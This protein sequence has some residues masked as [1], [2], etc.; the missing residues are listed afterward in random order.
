MTHLPPPVN[1]PSTPSI[2]A[3]DIN[4]LYNININ[5]LK[6]TG[7]FS[8][9]VTATNRRDNAPRAL[10][11]MERGGLVG[12][13]AAMVLHEK[14]ILR[15]ANH[16]SIIRLHQ[17]IQTP[18]QVF[19]ELDL[20]TTDLFEY[21]MIHKRLNEADTALVM[22]QLLSAVA[23]LHDTDIIH[24]DIKPENILI[25]TPADIKLADFGLA[26]VV[27]AWSVKNT[28]MGTS[29]YIAPEIIRSIEMQSGVPH[30]TTR[31]DVKMV[32]I[33]ACG[34]VIAFMLSGKPPF[35]GQVKTGSERRALLNNINR[36]VMFNNA[37]WEGVSE[38][39]KDLV[40]CLLEQNIEKRIT[41]EKALKH[42]F[43]ENHGAKRFAKLYEHVPLRISDGVQ[44]VILSD[45]E[46]RH[47][48]GAPRT[49]QRRLT[50][51]NLTVNCGDIGFTSAIGSKATTPTTTPMTAYSN[52][53]FHIS[54]IPNVSMAVK[55]AEYHALKMELEEMHTELLE[56]GDSQGDSTDFHPSA[57]RSD[58]SPIASVIRQSKKVALPGKKSKPVA[59]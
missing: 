59:V 50:T 56:A 19:F 5:D 34:V 1:V 21:I 29:Y 35:I 20:M 37:I 6:G 46:E 30:T 51:V 57:V 53:S 48:V 24:R 3:T 17:F 2:Q 27:E 8:R 18:T 13:K 25:N 44:E 47:D 26:K 7:A 39:A 40:A 14:E 58:I 45:G 52:A 15:R 4:A 28:P 9:V 10:K 31:D 36:G 38:E 41:A 22:V 42:P 55:D 23:Y 54:E 49:P 16:P 33:W 32:D 43:F 12:K 11:I